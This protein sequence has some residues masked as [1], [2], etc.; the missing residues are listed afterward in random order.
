MN[1]FSYDFELL[2]PTLLGLGEWVEKWKLKLDV[3][4]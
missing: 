1:S 2:L 4:V 3:P